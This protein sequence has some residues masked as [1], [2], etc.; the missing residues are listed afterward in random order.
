MVPADLSG[1]WHKRN[2]YFILISMDYNFLFWNYL[3]PTWLIWSFRVCHILSS[4][5]SEPLKATMDHKST[6][7]KEVTI[8][9]SCNKKDD[10]SG[11]SIAYCTAIVLS[12]K[13]QK[14]IKEC[15]PWRRSHHHCV[16]RAPVREVYLSAYCLNLQNTM[17][18]TRFSQLSFYVALR[19]WL[20]RI[21]SIVFCR[22]KQWAD[23]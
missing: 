10:L 16:P 9:N 19:R 5:F 23:R 11:T 22:F 4:P 8:R 14:S 17:H 18:F 20:N 7:E 2:H 6:K 3:S 12:K 13:A 15:S 1:P 21:K